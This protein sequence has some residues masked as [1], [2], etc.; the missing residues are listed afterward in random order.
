MIDHFLSKENILRLMV[1]HLVGSENI[2]SV[3]PIPSNL[4]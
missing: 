4:F 3:F 2:L 1:Q